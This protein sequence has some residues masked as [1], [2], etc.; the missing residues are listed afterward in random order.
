MLKKFFSMAVCMMLIFAI[1]ACSSSQNTA[2][3]SQAQGRMQDDG[4]IRGI[5]TSISST[6]IEIAKMSGRSEGGGQDGQGN[7]ER[8][9]PPSGSSA[10]SGTP[11][12]SGSA[13]QASMDTS[14]M[15]KSSYTID[16]NTKIVKRTFANSTNNQSGGQQQATETE[17]GISDITT[18][19]MVSVTLQDGS[20]TKAAKIVIT[21]GMGGGRGG[22]NRPQQGSSSPP[23]TSASAS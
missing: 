10:P 22:G 6:Q 12:A 14:N 13:P 8:Q 5:V 3:Q 21:E 17:A 7:R 23:S 4:S 15:E 11:S 9:N 18:G 16:S 19:T 20:D 2:T 1:T